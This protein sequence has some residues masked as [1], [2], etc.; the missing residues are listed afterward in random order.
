MNSGK[1]LFYDNGGMRM[2]RKKYRKQLK[3]IRDIGVNKFLFAFERNT[4]TKSLKLTFFGRKSYTMRT[5]DD[6]IILVNAL[7]RE[8]REW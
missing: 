6:A 7:N 8:I 2:D 3:E 5:K 1:L 4:K